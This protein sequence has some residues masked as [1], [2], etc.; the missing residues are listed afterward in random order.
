MPLHIPLVVHLVELS[1]ANL[2]GHHLPRDSYRVREGDDR[3]APLVWLQ[4]VAV[5]TVHLDLSH[6][7]GVAAREGDTRDLRRAPYAA[8]VNPVRAEC[9]GRVCEA[10]GESA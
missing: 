1:V 10:P 3:E 8:T 7:E 4:R 2:S 6:D 5:G 9:I